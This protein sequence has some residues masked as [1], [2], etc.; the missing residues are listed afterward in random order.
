MKP[1]MYSSNNIAI[2]S[3]FLTVLIV[4][5]IYKYRGPVA[6]TFTVNSEEIPT[7]S[8]LEFWRAQHIADLHR[9]NGLPVTQR[10]SQTTFNKFG[11][12]VSNSEFLPQVFI[13]SQ[14]FGEYDPIPDRFLNRLKIWKS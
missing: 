6:F 3:K 11:H 4:E 9:K 5:L 1:I 12:R 8:E 14:A 10:V 13:G 7:I 2:S